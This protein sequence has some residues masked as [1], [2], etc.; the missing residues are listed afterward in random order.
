MA[1]LTFV[2]ITGWMLC[3]FWAFLLI[4]L[5]VIVAR[6]KLVDLGPKSPEPAD[7]PLVSIVVPARD[8]AA[9]IEASLSS[10]LKLDYPNL[11]IIAVDDRSTDGTGEAMDR[12][13]AQDS[14]LQVVHISELPAGWLG[15]NHAMHHAAS[16]ARGE[17]LLFTDGDILFAPQTLRL[18]LRWVLDRRVDHLC[19]N[20]ELTGGSYWERAL[21]TC[22]GLMFFA[23]F[24]AW[25][26][27]TQWKRAYCGIGAFNLVRKEVYA[28]VEGFERLKMDVLD[29]VHL[30]KLIKH[31]GYRQQLLLGRDLISVRW[32]PSFWGVVRGL[33]KNG[34]ASVHYSTAELISTSLIV[35]TASMSPYLGLAWLPYSAAYGYVVAV[36]LMHATYAYLGHRAGG[37][38]WI[39]PVLPGMFLTFIFILWRSA[40]I[41]LRQGGVRWRDTLYSLEELRRNQLR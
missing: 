38:A 24:L 15:K 32:Q 16:V 36:T 30:G 18:A 13:A 4:P 19:L 11:E 7:W 40:I 34:F 2:T 27:P 33:E 3:A 6:W 28:A 14:R 22:F 31:S 12:L 17:W 26:I 8:E 41:T 21:V 5:W 23:G 37:S 29:D 35:L 10:L 25:A 20:P 39:F 1:F 9:M